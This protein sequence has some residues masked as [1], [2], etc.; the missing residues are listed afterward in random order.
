MRP[1]EVLRSYHAVEM[2]RDVDAILAHFADDATLQTPDRIRT[3][4]AE[5]Q[6]FYVDA[7]TRFPGLR[8][9]V[10]QSVDEGE[11]GVTAWSSVM[12]DQ[13]GAEL[14]L[15]GVLLAR[16]HDGK[17]VEARSYYDTGAYLQA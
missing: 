15:E 7:S 14:P 17:I 1:T 11:W 10:V 3:G 4:R 9:A 6:E 16:V 13:N 2:T 8:V 12:T 5:I